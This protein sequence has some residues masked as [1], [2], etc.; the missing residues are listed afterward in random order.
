KGGFGADKSLVQAYGRK[1][2]D[3]SRFLVP[4]QSGEFGPIVHVSKEQWARICAL[5]HRFRGDPP[6]EYNYG[7]PYHAV[8]GANSVLYLNLPFEWVTWHGDGSNTD[9]LG[10]AWD[11]LS[12][13]ESAK[14]Y[15]KDLSA[16]LKF[17]VNLARKEGHPIEF[18]T[19][20][21]AWTRKPTDPG[22]EFIH[23]VMVQI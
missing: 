14:D 9:Y 2:I 5:S 12:S 10:M 8:V 16:D 1:E 23:H 18:L 17:V 22:A 6:R 21:A 19:V 3:F 11:A 20:H 4:P 13:V 7:V 15:A